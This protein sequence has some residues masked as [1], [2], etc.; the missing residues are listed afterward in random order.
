ME[1]DSNNPNPENKE[2]NENQ[3]QPPQKQK[4]ECKVCSRSFGSE[5]GLNQHLSAK[6]PENKEEKKVIRNPATKKKIRNWVIF[7]VILTA[8]VYGFY[9]LSSA[10][11]LP[12]TD[13]TNHIEQN[14]ISH[15]LKEPM[16]L[17]VQ[18][19]MLEHSDGTGPPGVILNYDCK[20]YKCAPD[21]IQ[22]LE[23]FAPKYPDFVYVA[24]FKN[25]AAKIVLTR[26]NGI[27]ILEDYDEER[28]NNFIRS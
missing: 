12:P 6:H 27:E 15:I 17:K 20:N 19:H 5:D 3:E 10:K 2:G 4:F 23:S 11:N 18:K 25:M 16:Q 26:Q 24:P 21:L 14:P 1:S 9:S 8:V 7:L 28:I 22:K 13:F